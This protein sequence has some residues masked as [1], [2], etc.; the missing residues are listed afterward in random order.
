MIWRRT[1][2]VKG[3]SEVEIIWNIG[4]NVEKGTYRIQHF[5][6]YKYVFGGIFPYSG[7]TKNFEVIKKKST[8][9]NEIVI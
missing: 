7:S 3:S 6:T 1:Q 8:D 9:S 4:D 5:G 2:I